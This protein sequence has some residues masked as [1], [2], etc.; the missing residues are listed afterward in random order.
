MVIRGLSPVAPQRFINATQFVPAHTPGLQIGGIP[1]RLI[2]PGA[3]DPRAWRMASGGSSTGNRAGS[4]A[5]APPAGGGGDAGDRHTLSNGILRIDVKNVGA[6]LTSL[7]S[8]RTGLEYLWQG[9]PKFWGKHA[10][11]L[12]PI[13][14][15]LKGDQYT[16][17]GKTYRM[18]QHGLARKMRFEMIDKT[19]GESIFFKLRHD[20]ET[21]KS[22]PFKFEL[23][24]AYVLNDDELQ[25][26]Y[27][28]ENL[29]DEPMYFSIGAHPGFRVP[30]LPHERYDD[31]SLMWDEDVKLDRYFLEDGII[32]PH[33]EPFLRNSREIPLVRDMFDRD[34]IVLRNIKFKRVRLQNPGTGHGVTMSML[35]SNFSHFGIWAKPGADFVCLEPWCGVGDLHNASGS[36]KEKLG[37]VALP[38]KGIFRASYAITPS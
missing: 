32:A 2:A 5:G 18:N 9:N 3:G 36:I 6:E 21:L 22:Y 24:I 15:R 20:E 29:D 35:S 33:A 17:R 7:W 28:V 37:I 4:I 16:Y 34:A 13:V 8:D 11:V 25:V 19:P 31:Y 30:L 12:F 1:G 26:G 27:H 23:M 10:P 14:G 38:G